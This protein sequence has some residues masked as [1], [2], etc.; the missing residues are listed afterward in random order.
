VHVS[1]E[2]AYIGARP[3]RPFVDPDTQVRTVS[4]ESPAWWGWNAT[5]YAPNVV[6]GF[7]FTAGVR[8]IL[9]TRDL[10]P[11]PGDYDRSVPAALIVPRVPGEGREFYAK[12]GY[13]Y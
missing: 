4:P 3:T 7:D 13:S 11:A 2:L 9:G 1:S 6:A 8:N 10:M 5:I 12:L